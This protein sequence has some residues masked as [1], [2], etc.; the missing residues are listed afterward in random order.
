VSERA[1]L[2]AVV[3]A[4]DA[5]SALL[6]E[7]LALLPV[8][9]AGV[10]AQQPPSAVELARAIHPLLGPR[11]A[12]IIGELEKAGPAGTTTGRIREAIH[13]DQPDVYLTLKGLI[14]LRFAEKDP[15]SRPHIYRLGDRLKQ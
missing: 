6:R 13:Y 4:L 8:A 7:R 3:D 1:T 10:A 15:S 14:E 11:Q 9:A 5:A 12:Q 2:E